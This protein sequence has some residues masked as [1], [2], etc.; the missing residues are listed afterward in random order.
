MSMTTAEQLPLPRRRAP[1]P[2]VLLALALLMTA[3]GGIGGGTVARAADDEATFRAIYEKAAATAPLAGP[4]DGAMH[5][6]RAQPDYQTTE[7]A[8]VWTKDAVVHV[9]FATPA[10]SATDRWRVSVGARVGQEPHYRFFLYDDGS[11]EWT[12]GYD[13]VVQKGAIAGFTERLRDTFAIDLAVSGKVG[14]AAVNDEF[15]A[16]LPLARTDGPGDYGISAATTA[17]EEAFTNL[18]VWSLD[19]DGFVYRRGLPQLG[20]DTAGAAVFNSVMASLSSTKPDFGPAKGELTIEADDFPSKAADLG[21]RDFMAHVVFTS[22]YTP[23]GDENWDVGVIFRTRQ[24][25]EY[26]F[27]V[28]STGRW[29]LMLG[30]GD[31]A[32]TGFIADL[33]TTVDEDL[34]L[35]LIVI[36]DRGYV[37]VNGG[38]LTTLNLALGAGPGSVMIGSSFFN[39]NVKVGAI[40][41]YDAF[42]VWS[43]DD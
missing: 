38:F 43:L 24:T 23:S 32:Q 42:T 40:V 15:V 26:R 35:D 27:I 2:R 20:S 18:T 21:A 10:Q 14:Y 16:A 19:P 29:S 4:I 1:I 30:S 34:A 6:D 7:L 17:A 5:M 28:E 41:P 22:P 11:W 39:E 37:G 13:A 9:V 36:G 3:L 8:G 33:P 31:A 12:E 25:P